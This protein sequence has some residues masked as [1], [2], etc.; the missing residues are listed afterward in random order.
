L[1]RDVGLVPLP[2]DRTGVSDTESRKDNKEEEV[3]VAAAATIF[4]GVNQNTE[5]SCPRTMTMTNRVQCKAD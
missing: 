2:D 5:L 3:V 1:E 4:E